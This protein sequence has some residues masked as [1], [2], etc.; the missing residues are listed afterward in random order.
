MEESTFQ[1]IWKE[2]VQQ[3]S[4]SSGSQIG[5]KQEPQ[6]AFRSVDD[7]ERLLTEELELFSKFRTKANTPFSKVLRS[8][9]V[10]VNTLDRLANLG[11]LIVSV[12]VRSVV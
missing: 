8:V 11:T 2:A 3:Y 5:A 12:E 1:S 4:E 7:L 9:L 10:Q 6:L